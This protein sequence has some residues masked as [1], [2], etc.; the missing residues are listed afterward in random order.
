MRGSH[1]VHC[2]GGWGRLEGERCA[3]HEECVFKAVPLPG[4]I[5]RVVMGHW[6]EGMTTLLE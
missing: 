4:P 2:I 6:Y 5:R 1:E 3:E